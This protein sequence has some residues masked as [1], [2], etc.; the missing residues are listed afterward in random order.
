MTFCFSFIV[1]FPRYYDNILYVQMAQQQTVS[2][3]EYEEIF[4]TSQQC[5]GSEFFHPDSR[6]KKNPGSAS[7][8]KNLNIVKPIVSK[9][10][11]IWSGMFI[12]NPDLDFL[13]IPD[14]GVKK[15]PDP[16]HCFTEVS[17]THT[18]TH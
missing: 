4:R 10:S 14:P 1:L 12:S 15:A 13:L 5:Y 2:S 16:Q 11:E 8:S 17:V 7:A 9:L 6:V 3:G 18:V